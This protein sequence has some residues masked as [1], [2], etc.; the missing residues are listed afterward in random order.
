MQFGNGNC[1]GTAA[2]RWIAGVGVDITS[3]FLDGRPYLRGFYSTME[4]F[5]GDLDVD[6]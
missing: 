3:V 5:C 1:M 2:L 4:A 6:G